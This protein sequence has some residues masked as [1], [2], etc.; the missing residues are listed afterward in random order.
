MGRDRRIG[1][2]GN[3]RTYIPDSSLAVEVMLTTACIGTVPDFE[4][5]VSWPSLI[6]VHVWNNLTTGVVFWD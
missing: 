5:F 2:W 4:V 6:P 1:R 3:I